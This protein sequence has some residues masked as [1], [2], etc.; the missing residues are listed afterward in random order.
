[1]A[2]FIKRTMGVYVSHHY[3]ATLWQETGLQLPPRGNRR[4][5]QSRDAPRRAAVEGHEDRPRGE[6]W[7]GLVGKIAQA[8]R[9]EMRTGMRLTRSGV[10]AG[11]AR[12]VARNRGNRC[13]SG[14]PVGSIR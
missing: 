4:R 14:R 7:C 10:A 5:R 2:A 6:H 1:M 11:V 8:D 3:I 13:C 12:F 9:L